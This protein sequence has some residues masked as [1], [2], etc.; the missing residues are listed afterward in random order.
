[1]KTFSEIACTKGNPPNRE[2]T[3]KMNKVSLVEGLLVNCF[4]VST[5]EITQKSNEPFNSEL[6]LYFNQNQAY[7]WTPSNWNK[8]NQYTKNIRAVNCH[9]QVTQR[10]SQSFSFKMASKNHMPNIQVYLLQPLGPLW[11]KR[12]KGGR[13]SGKCQPSFRQMLL[14]THWQRQLKTNQIQL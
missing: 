8:S 4:K 11:S 13:G 12:W 5:W 14:L 7:P 6:E 10:Q 2:K 3:Y 1:M 9:W